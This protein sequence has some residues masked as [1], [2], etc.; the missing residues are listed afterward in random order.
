MKYIEKQTSPT[1]FEAW[2]ESKKNRQSDLAKIKDLTKVKTDTRWEAL[3]SKTE[4]FN[5]LRESL[6]KEQGFLCCYCQQKISLEQKTIAVEHLVAR[7]K[8]ATLVFEYGN[9]LA[10]CLGGKKEESEETN[11]KYCNQGRG[12]NHLD[13]TPLQEDCEAHFDCFQ[14]EDADERQIKVVGRSETAKKVIALLNLNTLKLQRLRGE[15]LSPFLED[16][17][18]DEAT[19]LL[20]KFRTEKENTHNQPLR[21]FLQVLIRLLEKNYMI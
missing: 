12:S 11:E 20:N 13:I 21:P 2:K 19:I 15:T 17:T 9:L 5:A 18:L 7:S 16:L 3:K 10:S 4:I 1:K 6:L 14:I 8:D